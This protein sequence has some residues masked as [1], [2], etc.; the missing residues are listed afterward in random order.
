MV[1]YLSF[2]EF[3]LFSCTSLFFEYS[4]KEAYHIPECQVHSDDKLLL[5]S[6]FSA[7]SLRGIV[8]E[9]VFLSYPQI[10]FLV[11]QWAKATPC[12][13]PCA[14]SSFYDHM[15]TLMRLHPVMNGRQRTMSLHP[16]MKVR[17]RTMRLH[18]VMNEWQL[19]YLP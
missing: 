17:Q 16:V 12:T 9:F 2:V 13:T 10:M 15:A 8:L 3:I 6:V 4:F 1:S 11:F 5:F 14:S 18:P 7:R 19:T